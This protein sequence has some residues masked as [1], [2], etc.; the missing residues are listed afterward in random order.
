MKLRER[1]KTW[2][3]MPVLFGLS[4]DHGFSEVKTAPV[5][6]VVW[7][8]P[9]GTLSCPLLDDDTIYICIGTRLTAI[10]QEGTNKWSFSASD[11]CFGSAAAGSDGTIY[12]GSN[13]GYLY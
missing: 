1:V 8:L 13:D 12:F 10:T 3:L 6:T 9:T 5:S 11:F 7:T 2:L 4:T